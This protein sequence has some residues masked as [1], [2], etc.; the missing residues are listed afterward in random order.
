MTGRANVT[1]VL[2]IGC[3]K[4]S[5][6]W[7]H[8]ILSCHPRV[9][10]FED[11]DPVTSTN[12]EAHFWDKNRDLGIDWY[13]DLMTPPSPERLTL[14]FTPEY[15]TLPDAAIAECKALNPSAQVIYIL[16]DPLA[17]AVSAMRMYMLWHL[18]QGYR[19]ALTLGEVFDL[20]ARDA[21]LWAHGAYLENLQ[22]WRR[23]YPDLILLNYEN[24]HD[25]RADSIAQIMDRLGL[26]TSDLSGEAR[27]NFDALMGGRVWVS[28]PFA[29]EREVLMALDGMTHQTRKACES[30][31][32]MTFRE[33]AR[34]LADAGCHR[35]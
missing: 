20:L 7:L 8:S 10:L 13:R 3:Q 24:F 15:A 34:L 12:K 23:H 4:G 35:R 33:G 1:D 5:T 18:G 30:E 26:P 16:R 14:D 6:S 31:L 2:C 19:E 25:H 28:E 21:R 27:A 9:W 17:R 29:M 11:L 32:G 22:A